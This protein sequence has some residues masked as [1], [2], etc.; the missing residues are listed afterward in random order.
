MDHLNLP[1]SLLRLLHMLSEVLYSC[2]CQ[3]PTNVKIR[4]E[5]LG[6]GVTGQFVR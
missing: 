3:I 1:A 5:K 4:G 2:I 6:L